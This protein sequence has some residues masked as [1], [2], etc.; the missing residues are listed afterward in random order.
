[1][2]S[3]GSW[4]FNLFYIYFQH[5]SNKRPK[6]KVFFVIFVFFC[7]LKPKTF[8][9]YCELLSTY[10]IITLPSKK[11]A[12]RG[13]SPRTTKRT[14]TP[15]Q[16]EEEDE[17]Q[18]FGGERMPSPSPD[19]A[20][21]QSPIGRSAASASPFR[22]GSA[23]K[24]NNSL[25]SS[26]SLRRSPRKSILKKR[27]SQANFEEVEEEEE[28]VPLPVARVSFGHTC[29]CFVNYMHLLIVLIEYSSSK[30]SFVSLSWEMFI[31]PYHVVVCLWLRY[32]YDNL[33]SRAGRC[34]WVGAAVCSFELA[35]AHHAS[36]CL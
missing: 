2:T 33:T 36:I 25:S 30:T 21:T 22:N 19:S 17:D 6:L 5:Q 23:S 11:L 18:S 16:Q 12:M 10:L 4:R 32:S 28:I 34:G 9:F 35:H 15:Q 31:Y 20:P 27:I 8:C 3:Y 13:E 1:M 24:Q 7:F 14:Q 26:S 29:V